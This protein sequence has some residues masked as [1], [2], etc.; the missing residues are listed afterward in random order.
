M[1]VP[2]ARPQYGPDQPSYQSRDEPPDTQSSV[3]ALGPCL[4][5]QRKV[6]QILASVHP[7]KSR[8]VDGH[9]L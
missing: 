1:K 7:W 6:G 8:A 5:E 4:H 3:D 2:I 9:Y